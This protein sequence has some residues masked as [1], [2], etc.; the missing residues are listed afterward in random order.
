MFEGMSDSQIIE[1]AGTMIGEVV[2]ALN[3]F[4]D[5]MDDEF[6]SMRGF[7]PEQYMKHVRGEY[8]MNASVLNLAVYRLESIK[9][10]LTEQAERRLRRE[11][12][13]AD[14]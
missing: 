12:P 6:I 14:E 11:R 7:I 9:R 13:T 1:Y 5:R 4:S 3:V 2:D 10:N 8:N